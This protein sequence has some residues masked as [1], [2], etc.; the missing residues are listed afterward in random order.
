MLQRVRF[1]YGCVN[2]GE[3]MK[4]GAF[5]GEKRGLLPIFV[6]LDFRF[7]ILVAEQWDNNKVVKRERTQEKQKTK[8][9]QKTG[10]R[11]GKTH[12]DRGNDTPGRKMACF[13][14]ELKVDSRHHPH[15]E[16]RLSDNL[17]KLSDFQ[18][19][20]IIIWPHRK[21]LAC[22]INAA[23][24]LV[25]KNGPGAWQNKWF[26]NSPQHPLNIIFPGLS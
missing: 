14:Y 17:G 19:I 12:A 6:L 21:Y 5:S 10:G 22:L 25:F 18:V 3:S 13:D 1:H 24:L 11:R 16:T 4:D 7:I 9:Q 23:R 2:M 26:M 20:I 15:I 8:M